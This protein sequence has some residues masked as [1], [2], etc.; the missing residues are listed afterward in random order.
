[1]KKA[2]QRNS[3]YEIVF[4][5]DE[6]K[7]VLN[8]IVASSFVLDTTFDEK[9]SSLAFNEGM[10]N[11]ALRILSVLHYKPSDFLAL[12]EGVERDEY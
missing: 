2:E 1:M 7:R 8:D 11:G 3:D 12:P 10:R 4:G 6:G 9:P 5:S